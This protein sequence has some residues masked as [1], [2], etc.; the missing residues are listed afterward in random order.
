MVQGLHAAV[1]VDA[2]GVAGTP[3]GASKAHSCGGR[4]SLTLGLKNDPSSQAVDTQLV[5][6][7]QPT[8]VRVGGSSAGDGRAG[9]A[10]RPHGKSWVPAK[11]SR[12]AVLLHHWK[13]DTSFAAGLMCQFPMVRSGRGTC[14]LTRS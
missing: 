11:S 1:D 2:E 14:V 3:S 4:R 7:G 13:L 5:P 8:L 6:E 10:G 12:P 9:A